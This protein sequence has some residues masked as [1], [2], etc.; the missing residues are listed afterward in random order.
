L[1]GAHVL[2]AGSHGDHDREVLVRAR[3]VVSAT[4]VWSDALR[5]L[6]P[7]PEPETIRP[8]KGVHITVPWDLVQNEVAAVVPVPGDRRSVFVVPWGDHTYVG[9]TD[10][11]YT[12]TL[13]EPRC[14]AEDVDYLLAALNA[15]VETTITRDDITG[16]WAGLRPLVRSTGSGRTADLSRRHRVQVDDDGLVSINGG[17]LTTYR[18]MAE[19]TVDEVMRHLDN[20]ATSRVSSRSRTK[21][22][23][24]RG[25]DGLTQM[26]DVA[27]EQAK[28]GDLPRQTVQHLVDRYGGD[29]R[30]LMAMIDA[31]PT[32]GAPIS[33]G[34]R[35]VRAEVAYAVRHEMATSL[36]D[37]LT[38]RV[39]LRLRDARASMTVADEVAAMMADDLAWDDGTRDAEVAT[40]RAAVADDLSTAGLA[41]SA[42]TA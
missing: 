13:D 26:R 22:L 7:E 6:G 15:S 3:Q 16:T 4:G 18:E 12:G 42:T 38:R 8:A 17:K 20:A 32:L 25:A 27:D 35:F 41:P 31:D 11:D 5:G 19:D 1:A 37:V 9:T 21:K 23:R 33:P 10:T 30:V 34:H 36:D 28:D 39:P 24:L 2:I 29:A 14:T 40:Y